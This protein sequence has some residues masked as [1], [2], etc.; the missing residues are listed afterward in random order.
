M[1][2]TN[3]PWDLPIMIELINVAGARIALGESLFS[4]VHAVPHA[5]PARARAA[6]AQRPAVHLA[7]IVEPGPHFVLIIIGLGPNTCN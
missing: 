3:E 2:K 4:G 1:L 6:A 7:R 5:V